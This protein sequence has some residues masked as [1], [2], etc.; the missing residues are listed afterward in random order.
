[1]AWSKRKTR[2][3]RGR[4]GDVAAI[5]VATTTI[6]QCQSPFLSVVIPCLDEEDTVGSCVR[7]ALRGIRELGGPGEVIVCDNGSVDDS[8]SLAAAAGARVVHCSQRGYGN[9]V[10][11]VVQHSVGRWIIMGDSDGSYDFTH[12]GPF[13]ERLSAGADLVVGNRFRGGIAPGAMPWKNRYVGNPGLTSILNALFRTGVD[14]S[15]C[16]LRAFSREAFERMELECDGMELATEMLIKA[17]LRGLVV[18]QVP[19]TLA[20]DGRGRPPHLSPWSDGLRIL[21]LLLRSRL[22]APRSDSRA[23]REQRR[24]ATRQQKAPI[25]RDPIT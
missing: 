16:G 2:R 5:A 13:V 17:S 1:M 3:S 11:F 8:A 23:H 10:R 7:A 20:K 4:V 9:A 18:E 15:L 25:A 22:T 19:V 14:D 6:P 24:A 21:S 12:L